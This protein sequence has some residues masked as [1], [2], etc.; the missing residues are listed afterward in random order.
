MRLF[1]AV[2][3]AALLALGACGSSGSGGK[4]VTSGGLTVGGLDSAEDTLPSKAITN[5]AFTDFD[6]KSGTFAAYVG[7]PM[8]V[9]FWASWCV[10]CVTEMPTFETVHKELGDKVTFVG[11]NVIDQLSEAKAMAT[12]TG[13]SYPLVRD[14]QGELLRWVGGSQMPTTAF[15]NADGS[16]A[17]VVTKALGADDLRKEI[18]A[19]H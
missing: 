8:V 1:A 15:V 4:T 7:H 14:P 6:D 19:L 2:G 10:P 11:V 17:K 16:V 9:N 13:V 18:A 3:V 12:K 5:E